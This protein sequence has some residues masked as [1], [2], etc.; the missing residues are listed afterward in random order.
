MS[1]APAIYFLSD[2]GI[3]DEFVGVV[4]AVLHRLAPGVPVI[5]LSHLIP[6]FD[7]RSG[8]SMLERAAPHLGHGIVLAVVDPG[9]GTDRRALAVGTDGP[10]PTWLV[11]PDNGLLAP[12]ARC[13]GGARR[14]V[15]LGGAV[16][17][18]GPA[19]LPSTFDGRDVFA[20]A[21]AWAVMG[22]DPSEL[23]TPIDPATLVAAPSGSTVGEPGE[24]RS[25]ASE[26]SVTAR[27][28][29]VDRFGN[30]QLGLDP[31]ELDLLGIRIGDTAE[32]TV[33][34]DSNDRVEPVA[35]R[36][37]RT[38]AALARGELGLLAD[39]NGRM[40]LAVDRASAADRLG[41]GTTE[42]V[43]RISVTALPSGQ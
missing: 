3:A 34:D 28:V 1:G 30:V 21:A 43:V 36:R 18:A 6:P 9:V 17:G 7:V 12:L 4:H 10:G 35:A 15:A 40:A 24:P 23:G 13:L 5:D 41:V 31:M 39:A 26:D 37:V 33:Y 16:P 22:R 25:P 27:V 11:G 42:A 14:A 2:Y 32:I 38:F 19:S 8:A 29:W 20:P